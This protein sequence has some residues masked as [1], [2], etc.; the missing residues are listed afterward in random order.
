MTIRV[1]EYLE[2][3]KEER[4][5]ILKIVDKVFSSGVLVLGEGVRKFEEEYSTYCCS[6]DA[7]GVDNATNGIF[8]ALKALNIGL[9]DEVITVSNTA[10]PTVSAIA[11]AGASAKFVDIKED[12]FLMDVSQ[13]ESQ[14]NKSTKAVIVVHLYGQCV[15][16]KAVKKVCK[17]HNL[18][19][20]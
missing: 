16:M 4:K 13:L 14:I 8:L 20:I 18:F 17:K 15:D 2:E 6:A 1:W 10:V 11:Q 12:S 9:G 5:D 3:Y 19:I 7:V